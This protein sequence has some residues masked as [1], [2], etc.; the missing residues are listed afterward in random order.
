MRVPIFHATV[1]AGDELVR[2][3][4]GE[5]RRRAQTITDRGRRDA[6]ITGQALLR[7]VMAPLVG[8][9]PAR[10][11][12]DRTCIRCGGPHGKPRVVGAHVDLSLTYAGRTVLLAVS[13]RPRTL[14]GLD[15]EPPRPTPGL[16]SAPGADGTLAQEVLGRAEWHEWQALPAAEQGPALVRWWTRKEA[17]LKALGP[18]LAVPPRAL[19]VSPPGGR[20]RLLDWHAALAGS[21]LDDP[22]ALADLDLPTVVGT[23][24]AVGVAD[25][26][27]ELEAAD[28]RLSTV[29]LS[30]W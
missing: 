1:R 10:I 15:A 4:D 18:G 12:L 17:V 22:V 8:V 9:P 13:P 27:P 14:V 11:A 26:E 23:L 7:V 30:P 16:G 21:H 2:L 28:L 20:P 3:L 19:R 24:A 29:A 25:L 6:H 5:S